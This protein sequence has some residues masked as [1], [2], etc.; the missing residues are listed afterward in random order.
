MIDWEEEE[1][2]G[3][4]LAGDGRR[5]LVVGCGLGA[6]AEYLA[7]LGFATT[8]FD[9]SEAA[10]RIA[11]QRHPGSPVHYLVAAIDGEGEPFEPPPWPLRRNEIDA[12]AADGLTA[13]G[14]EMVPV[15]GGSSDRRWRAQFE[16][17]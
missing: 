5:A 14:V 11:Q 4:N 3:A 9:I 1:D 12:F 13:V 6:D 7:G 10:I 2:R 8:G 15:P 16:R 17:R